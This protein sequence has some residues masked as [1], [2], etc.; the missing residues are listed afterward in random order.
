MKIDDNK[1][2]D[3]EIEKMLEDFEGKKI[4]IPV[5]LD[6]RLNEK[7]KELTPNEKLDNSILNKI[8]KPLI[9]VIASI[10]LVTLSY[11][12]IPEFRT[13]ADGVIKLISGDVGVDNAIEHGYSCIPSQ[14]INIG[15]YDIQISNIYIDK[16]RLGFDA[17]IITK[18]NKPIEK[19]DEEVNLSVSNENFEREKGYT[20]SSA[21]L[22]KD[23]EY[24]GKVEILG[25]VIT[26][27]YEKHPKKI[28]LELVLDKYGSDSSEVNTEIL[29]K[30]NLVINLPKEVY[31]NKELSIN[32][33]IRDDKL[34]LEIQRIEASPTMMYLFTKGDVN[35]HSANGLY[36]MR[37]ISDNATYREDLGIG[38]GRN[39][40]WNQ[41]IVPSIYYDNSKNIKLRADGVCVDF[42][43][44]INIDINEH[45]P[46]KIKYFND[47][48]TIN[49]VEKID[50]KLEVEVIGNNNIFSPTSE[51]Y[52][53]GIQSDG[54]SVGYDETK[55][56][57][58]YTYYFKIDEKEKYKL[59][60][61]LIVK[62]PKA[63]ELGI[64]AN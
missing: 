2:N 42:S 18:N 20:S 51:T 60:L 10:L 14:N 32:E 53:D 27:I 62:Y 48:I 7:L 58:R 44:D 35:G 19:Y 12:S 52:L 39:N 34:N 1:I 36:N 15:D 11:I 22:S 38:I 63:I 40:E 13:F 21:C 30:Y 8:R 57:G 28:E 41:T 4:E 47:T 37:I 50:G 26:E 43:D 24:K 49:R 16:L 17:K 64:K 61:S 46:K 25:E 29:G 55:E 9:V 6:E 56:I 5:E 45:Y 3:I 33:T 54:T 23:S 59:K 31:N